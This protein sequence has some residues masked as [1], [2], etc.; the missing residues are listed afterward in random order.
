MTGSGLAQWRG[1]P[2]HYSGRQGLSVTHITL[3]IMVGRL[4]G[5]DSCFQN[6][7]YKAASHYGVGGDGT[8]YQWVDEDDGSWADANWTSDCSGV[9]IEHEGGM[10]GVPVTDAEVEA[11]ARLCADIASRYG[12]TSLWHDGN[13]NRTGNVWLHREVPGTDHYGCPDRC[14]NALPVDRIITRAN[15]ILGGED[16]PTAE[17]I[18]HAVWEYKYKDW[19][20]G[21]NMFNLLSFELP[22][23]I[24]E[25]NY[26]K[27]ANGGNM[28]N[29]VNGT[30][31]TV[32][33][34]KAQVEAL[35]TQTAAL[36]E[37]VRTLASANGADPDAIAEA[38]GT[39]VRD[40]L[41]KLHVTVTSDE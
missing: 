32:S 27:T 39:A 34:L 1:S 10:E 40:R 33:A 26:K 9:T 21:G 17:E 24:W 37:A 20:T 12:W 36:A 8:V 19:P 31:A 14:V 23:L 35:E 3:H 2:N 5:T 25:Y 11:S 4:A 28:Y 6:S 41:A 16:M 30:S 18:A 15:E 22:H 38:V 29:A 13:G 7:S